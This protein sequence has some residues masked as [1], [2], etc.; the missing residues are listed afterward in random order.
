MIRMISFKENFVQD[1][2]YFVFNGGEVQ[3]S[4][5]ETVRDW[6][7]TQIMIQGWLQNSADV[8]ALLL[9]TDA[10]R[11]LYTGIN[12]DVHLQLFYFP[13]ARQD[14]EMVRGEALSVKV[15]A[16]LI[17]AQHYASVTV[18]D[19]HSD[20]TAALLDRVL[21]MDQAHIWKQARFEY[22]APMDH[23]HDFRETIFVAPD[24]G[25]MKKV[26]KLAETFEAKGVLF[27][28]KVRDVR[29]GKITHTEFHGDIEDQHVLVIDDI[30]DGGRTFIELAKV[31]QLQDPKSLDLFVTHGIFS[32]GYEEL[33]AYYGRI[34]STNS[35]HHG[36]VGP[37]RPDGVIDQQYHFFQ[38]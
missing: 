26:Q 30:C 6:A 13:Y 38:L 16:D 25:A 36:A 34:Y 33:K 29:T 12:L 7:D 37:K 21:V 18:L 11:R 3:V 27:A 23:M 32:Q 31:L 22:G 24:A 1:I 14:R 15:F 10:L 28:H 9:A 4:V 5:P 35:F 2:K 20:V 19:P 8:M 17:N